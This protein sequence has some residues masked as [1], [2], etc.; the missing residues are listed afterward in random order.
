MAPPL[1]ASPLPLRT[2]NMYRR[3]PSFSSPAK[4]G[5]DDGLED[6]IPCSPAAFLPPFRGVTQSATTQPTQILSKPGL[7]RGTQD[8]SSSPSV[9]EVPASSPIQ[10][11]VQPR[12]LG[13]R[14]APAGTLF[15]PPPKK[16][17]PAKRPATETI[18]LISDDD[19]DEFVAPRGE[20]RP[21]TFKAQISNFRYNAA[22]D[23]ATK[24]KLRQIYDVYGDKY[25]PAV[26]RT[27]LVQCHND[28]EAAID[29]LKLHGKKYRDADG[30]ADASSRPSARPASVAR[31]TSDARESPS[32]PPKP[33]RGRLIQ[34]LRRRSSPTTPQSTQKTQPPPSSD[35]PLQIIDLVDNDEEDAFQ[36]DS[37][38]APSDDGETKI[39]ECINTSSAKEL[40]AMTGLKEAQLEDLVKKAPFDSL[41][42]ARAVTVAKGSGKGK[43]SRQ[44]IGDTVV[45]AVEVFLDS[46]DAIDKVVAQ[47]EAKAKLVKDVIDGWDLDSFG[48]SR[49]GRHL[50]SNQ[51][52][53]PTPT[54]D[55]DAKLTRPP[56]AEPP[57]YMDGHCQMKPFQI[58]GLNWMSLLYNYDIGCILADDMGLGKTCQTISFVSHLVGTY[59]K[60]QTGT[61]PW[62]NLI[63]VPPSTCDNWLAEFAKFAPELSVIAYRGSQAERSEVAYEIDSNPEAYHAVIATYTQLSS[64]EDIEAMQSIKPHTAIFDEGHLLKN[65]ETARYRSLKRIP[66]TWKMLLSGTPVQNNL[67]EMISLLSFLNPKMFEGCMDHITHIFKQKVTVRDVGNGAFLYKERVQRARNILAPFLLQRVKDQVLDDMPQKINTIVS[68][69]MVQGQKILYDEYEGAF[70]HGSSKKPASAKGRGNDQNNPW[71]QLRKAALHPLLFRRHFTDEITQEMAEILMDR[72]DQ[73]ILR[74]PN[75][76]HLVQELRNCSDFDLHLWC[77]DY[78]ALLGKFDVPPS[79]LRDSGKVNKLLDLIAQYRK[80][81]D[82]VL[83][84]SKFATVIRLLNEV[85][86]KLDIPALVL[87]GETA[88]SERQD[89]INEFNENSDIP[90][91]L[92]T[93]GAG[94]TGINLTAANKVVIFDQSDNPQ[95]DVQAEN[96]AHRLG[97]TRDVEIVRLLSTGTVEGLIHEAC[98]KKLELAKKVTGSSTGDMDDEGE[99]METR[100]RKMMKE[101]LTPP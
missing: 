26:C 71:I 72:V 56:I 19:G 18:D 54:S 94:G 6:T 31:T 83:V 49:I 1:D 85:L 77:R 52:L 70:R 22:S 37:S 50:T 9:I 68:C 39:L 62:P 57:D 75:L 84:F 53:P 86:D 89:M 4:N 73:D 38:P 13:S 58:F 95:D 81:G 32:T 28:V 61:R 59:E 34:G 90:V 63:V 33:R 40:A 101:Q 60:K 91:F 96:R 92:L 20:I 100:V 30:G 98:R 15:R 74:Q 36:V 12:K 76:T 67:L 48:H 45:N 88:V 35:D 27:A 2:T 99:N 47:C 64:E 21:T 42:D 55:R 23:A 46:V 66:T 65:P 82:R 44:N 29:W 51:D 3:S 93:T 8:R 17:I 25:A 78:P 97:Q 87:A 10:S 79:A 41:D 24:T 69:D 80:N 7:G 5:H 43:R 16:H 14:L 11:P